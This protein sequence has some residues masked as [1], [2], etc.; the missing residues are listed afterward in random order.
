MQET[1]RRIK[2]FEGYSGKP[3]RCSA[4]KWTVGYGYNFEE[5]SFSTDVLV[6]I[7]NEGFTQEL[8]EKLLILD[9]KEIIRTLYREFPFYKKLDEARRFVVT[10]MVYQLGLSG[11]GEFKKT[12]RALESENFTLASQEMKDSLW[13][14]QSGRRSRIN[15]DQMLTGIWQEI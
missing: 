2:I 11:F 15:K 7:L 5:R 6:Q 3:Y 9:V 13:Y 8:A 1:V 14:R 4:G 10:D 12:L